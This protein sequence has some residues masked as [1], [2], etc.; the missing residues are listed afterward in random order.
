MELY[1]CYQELKS[2]IKI[3]LFS[4]IQILDK[5]GH[6][7]VYNTQEYYKRK[8]R[9][10]VTLYHEMPIHEKTKISQAPYYIVIQYH[11]QNQHY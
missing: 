3:L 9:D 1:L 6:A 10:G 7:L 11:D 4:N 5:D 8:Y 2:F